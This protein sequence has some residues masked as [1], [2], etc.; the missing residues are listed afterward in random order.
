MRTRTGTAAAAAVVTLGALLLS[1]CGG[2][3]GAA[4]FVGEDRI[5]DVTVQDW[6]HSALQ[7]RP[8]RAPPVDVPSFSREVLTV[9]VRE[10]L[11]AQTADRLDVDVDER[12]ISAAVQPL[13]D[14]A[15]GSEEYAENLRLSGD[16]GIIYTQGF[17]AG[18]RAFADDPISPEDILEEANQFRGRA[19]D[20]LPF[21]SVSLGYRF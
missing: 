4:A 13:V 16:V 14:A 3:P 5:A 8:E 18:L 12:S 19:W 9:L 7:D 11:L 15:G 6:V 17:V 21:L 1:G 20:A 2:T 10:P